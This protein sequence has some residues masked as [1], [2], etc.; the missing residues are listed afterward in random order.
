MNDHMKIF[1]CIG[2]EEEKIPQELF[3]D[4]SFTYREANEDSEG[5][6]A[7]AK[8]L[9]LIK[10]GFCTLPFCN[11]VEAEAFGCEIKF[12]AQAGNRVQSYPIHAQGDIE[13]LR[14]IDFSQGRIARVLEGVNRLSAQGEKVCLNILGPISISNLIMESKLFYRTYRKNPE[15]IE[16]LLK[17]IENNII[18]YMQQGIKMGADILSY[19]DPTGT[20]DILGP[21][22]YQEVSGPSTYRILK[23]AEQNLEGALL[24]ICGKTSTSLEKIGVVKKKTLDTA[25]NP[26][27]EKLQQLPRENQGVKFIG[28]WCMKSGS[29]RKNL[30]QLI[31]EENK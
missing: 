24:H 10:G 8:A 1:K 11:T 2:N 29:S 28:H 18:H 27:W 7:L 3:Q 19:S 15:I 4:L 6:I 21:K 5:M 26:Y 17:R 13:H 16:S 30:T 31:L 22:F 14:D 23:G 12:D 20:M 25:G 9:Q